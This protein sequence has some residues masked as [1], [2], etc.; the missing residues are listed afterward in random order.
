[1]AY[2]PAFIQLKGKKVLLLGGGTVAFKK[3]LNLLDFTK[4]IFVVAKEFDVSMRA[5]LEKEQISFEQRAY[6][7]NESRSFD[8]VVVAVDD[9]SLQKEVYN[10]TRNSQTLCNCVDLLEYCD[11]I[12]PAYIK[13]DDLILAISTSGSSPSFAKYFKTYLASLL[14]TDIGEFLKEM[15]NLRKSL[16]K[17]EKRM[18]LFDEKVKK[19]I[20]SINHKEL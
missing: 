13:Q 16:P 12:F 18:K 6:R 5:L 14:P 3:L 17:G 19:Y 1:M 20:K 10:Q 2:F 8:I 7:K 4:E 11:F 9:L 15:K